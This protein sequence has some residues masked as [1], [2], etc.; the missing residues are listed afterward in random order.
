MDSA[1]KRTGLEDVSPVVGAA[2]DRG[3][4]ELHEIASGLPLFPYLD[5]RVTPMARHPNAITRELMSDL[6]PNGA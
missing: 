2:D 6:V 3:G 4:D 5:I 1:V